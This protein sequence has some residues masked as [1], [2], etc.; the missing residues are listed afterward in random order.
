MV[1]HRII[2][3]A[4]WLQP[5]EP[6]LQLKPDAYP[7]E[8]PHQSSLQ[9]RTH[10]CRGRARQTRIDPS[11]QVRYPSH[12]KTVAEPRPSNREPRAGEPGT[13]RRFPARGD[14]VRTT[15]A[16]RAEF[17]ATGGACC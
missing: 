16:H 3:C 2:S 8:A 10:S 15:A 6:H 12:S 7:R 1:K 4:V 9:A 17:L 14:P 5:R 13:S 11:F